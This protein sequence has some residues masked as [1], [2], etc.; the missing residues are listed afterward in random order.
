MHRLGLG[1]GLRILCTGDPQ[2]LFHYDI[3][4]EINF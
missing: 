4:N 1:G 2:R 3:D